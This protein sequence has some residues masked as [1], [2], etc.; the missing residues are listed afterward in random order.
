MNVVGLIFLL[1]AQ[2]PPV[3]PQPDGSCTGNTYEVATCLAKAF[4]EIDAELNRV[5][6]QS[7]KTVSDS[8]T[9]Q[10]KRNLED[11]Q[12]KWIAYRDATCKAELALWGGGTGGPATYTACMIRTTKHRMEVLNE[13][14]LMR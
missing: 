10:D 9:Q 3:S 6:R 14:Y 8:Y 12:R 7:L 2:S 5:Y 11:A 13:A 1:V 4:K